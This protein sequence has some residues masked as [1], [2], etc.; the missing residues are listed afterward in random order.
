[1]YNFRLETLLYFA[2]IRQLKGTFRSAAFYGFGDLYDPC[3][4]MITV[5]SGVML[6]CTIYNRYSQVLKI[7][8]AM[9]DVLYHT[10]VSWIF[11]D[12]EHGYQYGPSSS[13]HAAAAPPLPDLDPPA[14]TPGDQKKHPQYRRT[15]PLNTSMRNPQHSDQFQADTISYPPPTKNTTRPF[16]SATEPHHP[17]SQNNHEASQND[18][19]NLIP[20]RLKTVPRSE[21]LQWKGNIKSIYMRTNGIN[22]IVQI[23]TM[24]SLPAEDVLQIL[25]QLE[26][27]GLISLRRPL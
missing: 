17:S 19:L 7:T 25:R 13:S 3:V 18:F 23:A 20:L 22:T 14:P 27:D 6:S 9:M 8:A 2:R 24:L 15:T 4:V 26:K 5:Q 1:M 10:T 11:E 21:V 16:T 12:A